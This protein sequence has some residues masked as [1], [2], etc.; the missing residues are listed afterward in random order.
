MTTQTAKTA[1]P[2]PQA[3]PPEAAEGRLPFMSHVK[4]LRDR[5]MHSV[6]AIVITTSV[7]MIFGN[8]IIELLKLPAGDINLIAVTLLENMGVYFKVS[9]A[10][11]IIAAMPVLVYELF[12][13]V[14]PGLTSR[15][16]RMILTILPAIVFMFLL[17][18]AF[19]YFAALPPAIRF[20]YTFNADAA[21]PLP[22]IS[23]YVNLVT[24]MLLAI[25]LVFETPL[26]IMAL[27]RLGVVSP[28]W[29]AARR[30]M[31]IV[32]AF[33]L[34][35]L[36]TPT[37]DP[38]NQTIIAVPLILLLELGIILARMVYKKKREPSTA[39]AS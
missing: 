10:A 22:T 2:N 6:I 37:F 11:G 9:L 12:A 24:R 39:A 30:R 26:I 5:V 7:A 16:K 33:V 23:D 35:A 36:I 38:I 14:A 20:L 27:A 1:I 19:A 25:G 18:V 8:K 3:P 15:E 4:E 13:F 34:S 31:W 17:G 28:Q 29:L 21:T 32:V